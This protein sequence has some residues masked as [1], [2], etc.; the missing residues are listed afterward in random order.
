MLF[1]I[2]L[3]ILVSAAIA[4]SAGANAGLWVALHA[5]GGCL[6]ALSAGVGM[7][8]SLKGDR[9]QKIGGSLIGLAILALSLWVSE[10][11]SA[12]LYG[13][14][15]SGPIWATIGLVVCFMFS[16]GKLRGE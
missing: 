13:V 15:I 2:F 4:I 11:F 12:T 16:G 1:P 3:Y 6:L 7:R 8:A 5:A 9:T 14:S 10:G